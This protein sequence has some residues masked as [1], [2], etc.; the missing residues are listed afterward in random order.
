MS[1]VAGKACR[2]ET[3]KWTRVSL[4]IHRKYADYVK[5]RRGV[6]MH[7]VNMWVGGIGE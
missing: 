1:V 5:A 3:Y 6:A 4:A 2:P 7:G